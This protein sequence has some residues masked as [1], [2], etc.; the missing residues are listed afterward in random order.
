[1]KATTAIAAAWTRGWLIRITEPEGHLMGYNHLE[2]V[3]DRMKNHKGYDTVEL[4]KIG[5]SERYTFDVKNGIVV[6]PPEI[7]TEM[8]SESIY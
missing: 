2:E 3:F 6:N 8:M 5:V 4:A 7:L 1:M